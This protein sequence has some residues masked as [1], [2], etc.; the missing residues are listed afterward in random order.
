MRKLLYT[1][2]VIFFMTVLLCVKSYA[3]VRVHMVNGGDDNSL[4]V[5]LTIGAVSSFLLGIYYIYKENE[6]PRW[7]VSIFLSSV[8]SILLN[9]LISVAV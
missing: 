4:Y 8:I 2:P 6:L 7:V 1:T 9:L 5:L 3:R